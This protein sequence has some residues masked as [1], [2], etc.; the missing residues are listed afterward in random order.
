M[1][2]LP[3]LIAFALSVNSGSAQQ[4][5]R[6]QEKLLQEVSRLE[7]QYGG[8]LGL[9]ARNLDTGDTVGYNA[10]ERFRWLEIATR[11]V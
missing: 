1:K 11:W 9:M 5:S 3:I 6:Q 4:P 7:A 10:S 2:N 8:H